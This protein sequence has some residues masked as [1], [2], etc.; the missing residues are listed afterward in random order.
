MTAPDPQTPPRVAGSSLR[1]RWRL[2]LLTVVLGLL[3]GLAC[4]PLNRL[5]A[6]QDRLLD[7]LPLFSGTSWSRQGL[8]PA[9]LPLVAMPLLLLL[10]AGPLRGADGSGIPQVILSLRDPGQ[11]DRLLRGSSTL[12]R[13]SLWGL[14]SAG[15]L[16][17]GR[18][19]PLVQLGAAIA[20]GLRRLQPRLFEGVDRSDLLAA[21]AATGLAGGFNAPLMGVL[22][23][24]EDLTLR[25]H[26]RLVWP[27]LLMGGAASVV[28]DL[29]HQPLFLLGSSL[30]GGSQLD[31]MLWAVPIG[32]GAGLLG[33][34]LPRG[35]LLVSDHLRAVALRQPLWVGGGLAAILSLLAM[36]S[37]GGSAGDGERL[38]QHLVEPSSTASS[39]GG[40]AVSWLA[41]LIARLLGPMLVL[42][43]GVPGGLIDPA[44]AL[45]GLV[46]DGIRLALDPGGSMADPRMGLALGMAAGLGGA[47]QLP[48]TT[49]AFTLQLVGDL[50]LLPGL[51]TASVLGASLGRMLMAEPI[52]HALVGRAVQRVAESGE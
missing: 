25:F 12:Q 51:L 18:E 45:G 42:G 36:I 23:L 7:P 11:A 21:A 35:I 43:A 3:V 26:A 10:M 28:S 47:V 13:L 22:F 31:Q 52:Y 19:G 1:S 20:H 32:L 4:W 24:A 2:L 39:G 34:I 6:L 17:I 9:F 29:G 15:L 16:P 33:A 8:L 27:A 5:D 14:A 46:G 48:M 38:L 49:V 40:P 30:A 37:E 50:T 41:L 44:L